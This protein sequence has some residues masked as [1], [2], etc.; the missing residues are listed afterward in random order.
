LIEEAAASLEAFKQTM[1]LLRRTPLDLICEQGHV[2]LLKYMLPLLEKTDHPEDSIFFKQTQSQDL[3]LLQPSSYTAVQRSAEKGHLAILQFLKEYYKARRAPPEC[4]LHYVEEASGENCALLAC[5]TG[6]LDVIRFLHEE[7]KADFS[8]INK[9]RESAIQLAA[10][11]SRKSPKSSFKECFKYLC[12][13]VNVDV[14]HEHEET[15]L[16]LE[17][18]RLIEYV[19]RRLKLSGL[20]TT[21]AAVEMKSL[22]TQH[23]VSQGH[24]QESDL[25]SIVQ[26]PRSQDVSELDF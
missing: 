4:D 18:P 17:D 22:Q 12:E 5:K 13:V 1:A 26:V 10:V 2:L 25:S 14:S 24:F 11:G 6:K 9:R 16:L 3:T 19:E 23:L 7:C 8:L 20:R 21:K 15:L